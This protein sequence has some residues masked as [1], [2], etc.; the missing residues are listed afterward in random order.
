M[1]DVDLVRAAVES[2]VRLTLVPSTDTLAAHLGHLHRWEPP[3]ARKAI[4][5]AKRDGSIRHQG[6]GL[7]WGVV[8]RWTDD[9]IVPVGDR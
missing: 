2:L 3:R 4:R 8:P 1:S 5:E 9:T 6:P 7:G